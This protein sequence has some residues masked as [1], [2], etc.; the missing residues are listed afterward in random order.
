MISVI[1]PVHNTEKYLKE[2]IESII[3]QTYYDLEI[4]CIDSSTDNSTSILERYSG[5]DSR[6]RHIYDDNS[7]YG[8]KINLGINIAKGEYI[9]IVDSDDYIELDMYESLLKLALFYNVDFVK[10]DFASFY[11]D[12]KGQKMFVD[13]QLTRYN[14]LY[15]NVFNISDH[16]EVLADCGPNIWTGLYRTEF[17]RINNIILNESPGASFQDTGFSVLTLLYARKILFDHGSFYRY[18]IDNVF[19]SSK[20]QAKCLTVFEEFQWIEGQLRNRKLDNEDNCIALCEKKLMHYIWNYGRLRGDIALQF[21]GGIYE[22]LKNQYI[23]HGMLTKIKFEYQEMFKTLFTAAKYAHKF[24]EGEKMKMISVIVPI[25]NTE[26]YV[27]ECLDSILYQTYPN[28]EVL[29]IDSSTDETTK[30]VEEMSKKDA[31]IRHIIDA[32]SSYG[33]KLNRGISEAKG[34]Y[35]GIIDSDDYIEKDMYL[36]LLE[37]A[38]ESGAD[39]VKADHSSFYTQNGENIVFRYDNTIAL[40]EWYGHVM[41][42]KDAPEILYRTAISIWSGLYRTDFLRENHI[43]AHESPAASYQDAGFSVLTYLHAQKI[44][45]LNESYYRYRTDNANSSVKSSKKV[46]T[47]I[48]EFNWIDKQVDERKIAKEEVLLA[49]RIKKL[50]AY[51]WNFDRLDT[52]TGIQFAGMIREELKETI[53]DAGLYE[54]M[55]RDKKERF[56]YL[57]YSGMKRKDRVDVSVVIPVYNTEKYLAECLD[58]VL[59]QSGVHAEFICVND[60]ST[61]G[62]RQILAEYQQ[63]EKRI[64]V[65]DQENAGLACARN[66]GIDAATGKYI[67]FIDSDDMLRPYSLLEMWIQAEKNQTEIVCFD[68]QCLYETEELKTHDNK[69]YYYQRAHSFGLKSGKDMFTDLIEETGDFCDSACLLFINRSWM[70]KTQLRFIPGIFYEDSPFSVDCMMKAKKVLHVNKQYYIYRVRNHSIMTTKF[71]AK[72][73]YGRLVGYDYLKERYC[74]ESMTVRQRK[75]LYLY[76]GAVLWSGNEISKSLSETEKNKIFDYSLSWR[77]AIELSEFGFGKND[78]DG[79]MNRK[80]LSETLA[81]KRNIIIYGAGFRTRKLLAYIHMFSIKTGKLSVVV[82]KRTG[83]PEV[84]EC[85]K[86]NALDEG[87]K[88]PQ[89]AL[90]LVPLAGKTGQEVTKKLKKDGFKNVIY[91]N[92]NV[93]FQINREMKTYLQL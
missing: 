11:V 87:Y 69:D 27:K 28:L 63:K 91:L 52:E 5:T 30:I 15:G 90:V 43:I 79:Y 41:T 35:I 46:S 17:L 9:A 18:R 51:Y 14:E 75:A 74:E 6:I 33:Y 44:Y 70:N 29:C 83:N 13:N 55:E 23:A 45:H 54:E 68:A 71:C 85:T 64:I 58:S 89:D 8:Y 86:V 67:V 1:V 19:S 61:D 16:L 57:Y 25:H 12:K 92:D 80:Y 82:S 50:D 40:P 37:I 24:Y 84:I 56:D 73:L 36:R 53:L 78:I 88:I 60:G 39:F 26:K 38:E 21:V 47:V 4:I 42:C 49:L 32:N 34:E 76:M 62:S 65:I 66:A 81:G 31:R 3:H 22:E 93:F 72:N 77:Q 7:S 2:C 20:S 59:E 10:T 48:D